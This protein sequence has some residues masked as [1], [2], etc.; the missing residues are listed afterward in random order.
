MYHEHSPPHFCYLREE[1][2]VPAFSLDFHRLGKRMSHETKQHCR[3]CAENPCGWHHQVLMQ[4]LNLILL[5]KYDA[6]HH[7]KFLYKIYI[8]IEI[9]QCMPMVCCIHQHLSE[10]FN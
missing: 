9:N 7:L 2:F 10:I 8:F 5:F 4:K 1:Q 6:L 3:D